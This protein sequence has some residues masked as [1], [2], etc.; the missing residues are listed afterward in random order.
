MASRALDGLD[1]RHI[2]KDI[3]GQGD[4]FTDAGKQGFR[5][6][7]A[8]LRKAGNAGPRVNGHRDHKST[9]CPGDEIYRWLQTEKF[10]GTTSPTTPTAPPEDDID[11]KS[12]V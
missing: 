8:W 12:V 7:V 4:G 2:Q 5:D 3:G 9:A 6:A 10:S 1:G 11:R